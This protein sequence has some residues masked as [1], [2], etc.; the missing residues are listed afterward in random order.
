M[1]HLSEQDP[2]S[3]L[4][5]N[6]E[7]LV[8]KTAS[9]AHRILFL[10]VLRGIAVLAGLLVSIWVYG[11]F[12][13]NMQFNLLLHPSGG[14]YRLYATI[15][16]LL[17]GKM[18]TLIALI[19]G[20]GIVVMLH[21]KNSLTRESMYDLL[22]RRQMWLIIFGLVNA[23]IFFATEEV[24]F[25]LGIMGL[26]TFVFARMSTR[27]LFIAALV[28]TLIYCG[29][30]YW[31]YAEDHTAYNKYVAVVAVEKKFKADSA[32]AASK[33][34]IAGLKDSTAQ[35]K[36]TLTRQQ[37]E[38]KGAWE[39][40]VNNLK[41]DPKKDD[42]EV[43]T[44]RG[45]SYG[46]IWD[47]LLGSTQWRE[48]KWTYTSGIWDFAAAIFLG[49]ALFK[50]S[51]FSL[52]FRVRKYIAI[53]LLCVGAGL[54]LGWFRIYFN[55]ATLLNYEKYIG[56]HMVPYNFFF[57][58]EK[59]LLAAGYAA[60]VMALLRVK[61]LEG[62][63]S[64]LS[65]VGKMALTNYLAQ[66]LFITLF[67][68][69]F[70]MTWYGKLAQY[71]LYFLVAET[72]L[73]QCVFSVFWLRRF[74]YGPFEWLLRCLTYKKWLPIRRYRNMESLNTGSITSSL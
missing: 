50:T 53:G 64:I 12:S 54:L 43:K 15:V 72:W 37:K 49:M 52:G 31:R 26:L 9:I 73:V 1:D 58:F 63:W 55:N 10:D 24:L 6:H 28:T 33:N 4:P 38:D 61:L 70:G 41:Y 32:K 69:G 47:H 17:E 27:G 36:D 5:S 62:L 25:H 22:V 65:D 7:T 40:I 42:E 57:P 74:T 35:K 56:K 44:M 68:D 11:G 18:R 67:F 3:V 2:A 30:I 46:E 71:Q 20:A 66:G 19:F 34:T 29:K 21:R 8:S 13:K 60:L 59:L 14:N 16:L 23:L 39:G 48:A 45:N 51:F